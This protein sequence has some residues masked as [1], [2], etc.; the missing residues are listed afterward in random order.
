MIRASLPDRLSSTGRVATSGGR[1]SQIASSPR[2][3]SSRAG[4]DDLPGLP[5]TAS[6]TARTSPR[7]GRR[8]TTATARRSTSSRLRTS[9]RCSSSP[10]RVPLRAY[11]RRPR[12]W[13]RR[14]SASTRTSS[15]PCAT[16]TSIRALL[17]SPARVPRVR[18]HPGGPFRVPGRGS[19][20]LQGWRAAIS[21]R[22]SGLPGVMALSL[23]A[24]VG[25]RRSSGGS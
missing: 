21:S 3:R 23:G 25:E 13:R 22:P 17:S 19:G 11:G 20:H 14:T 2:G 7:S 1:I 4:K 5:W 8:P 18:H 24:G 16:S 10:R 12:R 6:P 15:T 9:R